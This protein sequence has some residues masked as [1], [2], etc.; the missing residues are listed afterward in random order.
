M[1]GCKV[2]QDNDDIFAISLLLEIYQ[3]EG[4]NFAILKTKS[5]S[6]SCGT[7][8]PAIKL[9]PNP[10][11]VEIPSM[12]VFRFVIIVKKKLKVKTN[13]ININELR[14]NSNP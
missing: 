2:S 10:I 6:N 4:V 5:E 12:T 7:K 14:I 9:V 13:I 3:Y 11:T 8:A 1:I